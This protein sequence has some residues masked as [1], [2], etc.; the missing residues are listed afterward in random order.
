MLNRAEY[1]PS[2]ERRR[3]PTETGGLRIANCELRIADCEF[4]TAIR[5]PQSFILLPAGSLVLSPPISNGLKVPRASSSRSAQNGSCESARMVSIAD[6]PVE[7]EYYPLRHPIL[8][9]SNPIRAWAQTGAA[10]SLSSN[11]LVE[12]SSASLLRIPHI[13]AGHPAPTHR[14]GRAIHH[15]CV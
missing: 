10:P 3:G 4:R 8:L 11:P 5:N 12:N 9:L 1:T 14:A 15:K 6:A 2:F 7:T 13:G